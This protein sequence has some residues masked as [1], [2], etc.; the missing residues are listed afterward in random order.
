MIVNVLAACPDNL[1]IKGEFDQ[2]DM[3]PSMVRPTLTVRPV[4]PSS[5]MLDAEVRVS[6]QRFI[7]CA[8]VCHKLAV[9]KAVPKRSLGTVERSAF[10]VERSGTIKN[11][12]VINHKLNMERFAIVHTP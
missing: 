3:H 9:P 11:K 8:C 7:Y 1:S 12:V 2:R 5:H 10:Q 4:Q 6:L